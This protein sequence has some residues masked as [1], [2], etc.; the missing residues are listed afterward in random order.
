M[1]THYMRTMSFEDATI[2][3]DSLQIQPN[4]SSENDR[5]HEQ[6]WDE[7][8]RGPRAAVDYANL[9][10]L[11]VAHI[12]HTRL[13]R[14]SRTIVSVAHHKERTASKCKIQNLSTCS[15]EHT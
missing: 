2:F 4:C 12:E 5:D 8:G 3:R 14:C 1:R 6:A 9:R 10:H 13:Q 7:R 11:F 15:K